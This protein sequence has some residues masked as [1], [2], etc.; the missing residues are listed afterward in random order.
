MAKKNKT[1]RVGVINLTE[2]LLN[3][4]GHAIEKT[5]GAHGSKSGKKGYNRKRDKRASED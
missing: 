3:Q 5:G 4:R 1:I 2:I